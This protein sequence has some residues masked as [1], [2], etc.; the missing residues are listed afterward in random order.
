MIKTGGEAEFHNNAL[1]IDTAHHKRLRVGRAPNG[2]SSSAAKSPP[3]AGNRAYEGGLAWRVA[4]DPAP[5]ASV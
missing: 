2:A 1:G 5:A 3:Y 4:Q